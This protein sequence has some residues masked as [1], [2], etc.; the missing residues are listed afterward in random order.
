MTEGSAEMASRFGWTPTLGKTR[1]Y[2]VSL[3]RGLSI[4]QCFKS[5]SHFLGVAEVADMLG[6][7]RATTHRYLMTAVALG[8]LEQPVR[9]GRKYCLA[10]GVHDLGAAALDSRPLRR[11]ARPELERLRAE[12]SFTVSLGALD[13]DL[14]VMDRLPGHRGH[15]ELKPAIG[16]GSRL[17]LHC[18]IMGKVL[19]AHLPPH[20]LSEALASLTLD[21]RG[22]SAARRKRA[23]REELDQIRV[24]GFAVDDGELLAGVRSIAAP[25]RTTSGQVAGALEI[26]APATTIERLQMVERC[27]P[28]LL[29]SSARVAASLKDEPTFTVTSFPFG[30]TGSERKRDAGDG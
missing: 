18:T 16:V 20:E 15:A 23:L 9:R 2:S 14:F 5:G 29:R 4:L 27:G 17:P 26:A 13:S 25:L 7:S 10:A 11:I 30:R 22:P 24:A 19:L 21:R 8:L 3:E 28:L 6:M 12:T 1:Q